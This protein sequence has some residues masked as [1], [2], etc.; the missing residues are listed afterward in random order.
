MRRQ[1]TE[2]ILQE[3]SDTLPAIDD[4][5]F[6]AFVDALLVPGRRVLLMGVGRVMISL[7]AWVKRMK[8]LDVDINYVGDET[9]LPVRP[10]DLVVIGSSSGESKLPAAIAQIAKSLGASVAYIGCTPDSTV[11]KLADLRVL[12]RGRTKFAAPNEYPSRQ[13]MS[14][15]FEQ[16]LYLLGDVVALEIMARRGWAENDIKHRHANLE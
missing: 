5:E 6:S 2:L 15:L 4:A 12:L 8:H 14:T 10:G 3:L 7:K 1:A 16:Q 13:P 11:A 9:E